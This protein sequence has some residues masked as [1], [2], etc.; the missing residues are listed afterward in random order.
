MGT[1]LALPA[2]LVAGM[3]AA[4]PAKAAA[5][6]WQLVG[7]AGQR[8]SQVAV[9]EGRVTALV[10][11]EAM[12][13]TASGFVPAAAP[14]PRAPAS[15]TA[16]TRTWS[17]DAAGDVLVAQEQ[18]GLLQGRAPVRD[19]GSPNLGPGAHLIAAPLAT[20]G[21][22]IAVGDSGTVWCRAAGG[23]W[24]VSLLLL[25]DTLV[26]GTP[27]VTGI[28]AFNTLAVSGVVY[29]ATDGYGTLLTND[30]GNDWT[31][32]DAGLPDDVLSLV[33]DPSTTAPAVWAATGQGLYVHHLQA[34]PRIPNYSGGSLTGKW[35]IT[36]AVCVLVIALG[37]TAL[38]VWARRTRRSPEAAA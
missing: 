15:V 26:T 7:F 38:V 36:I 20:P 34:I 5:P 21:V 19:P 11:D 32:A 16:G 33:A 17:I 13:Q 8:V 18:G 24:S 6:W 1:S 4:T 29:L 10:G 2:F 23:G 27:A 22:V 28:A 14:L 35:L 12:V 25:P 3:A 31:R 37:G 30:G 9:V